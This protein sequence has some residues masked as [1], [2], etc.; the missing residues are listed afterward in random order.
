MRSKASFDNST[1]FS[2]TM[3]AIKESERKE[4]VIKALTYLENA[5]YDRQYIHFNINI[6]RNQQTRRGE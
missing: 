1:N 4:N 3:N 2:R 6:P 5:W